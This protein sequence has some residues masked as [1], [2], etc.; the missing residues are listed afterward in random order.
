MDFAVPI[1][2]FEF[3]LY[4]LAVYRLSLLISTEDGPAWIFRKLR[5]AVPA[6]SSTKQGIS[7]QLCVSV[8]M[9]ILVTG[10]ILTKL[11]WPSAPVWFIIA[12][13]GLILMLALSAGAII[14]HMH[15]TKGL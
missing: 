4:A 1:T 8:W 15:T 5:R 11:M 14:A 12:G 2:P 10:F 13:D 9:A 3:V 6:K 7:C